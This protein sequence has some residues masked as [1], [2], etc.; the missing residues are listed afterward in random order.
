MERDEW[1]ATGGANH[2][3][4]A[5]WF[6]DHDIAD[7]ST[8]VQ[9]T[10]YRLAAADGVAC[11]PTPSFFDALESPFMWAYLGAADENGIPCS[12]ENRV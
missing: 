12:A 4:T 8:L 5:G 11:A 6:G 2:C 1:R 7:G 3:T 10:D 9:R